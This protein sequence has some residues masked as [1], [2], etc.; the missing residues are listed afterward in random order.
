MKRR[1]SFFFALFFAVTGLFVF[2]SCFQGA[3]DSDARSGERDGVQ[4]LYV[5]DEGLL[6][7]SS[8][9]IRAD[10]RIFS[11]PF[12]A[13][14]KDL[15]LPLNVE[16]FPAEAFEKLPALER[17][18]CVGTVEFQGNVPE[19]IVLT[20]S[21][22]RAEEDPFLPSGH[23]LG[24]CPG[25][26]LEKCL[27]CDLPLKYEYSEHHTF[28]VRYNKTVYDETLTL[29]GKSL[30]V[31]RDGILQAEGFLVL[32]G[33]TRYYESGQFRTGKMDL[34]GY[35]YSFSQEGAL[36]SWKKLDDRVPVSLIVVPLLGLPFGV[37]LCFL[38]RLLYRKKNPED[39]L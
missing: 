36:L 2:S 17:V 7:L 5:E 39:V 15:L 35:R 3:Q 13:E 20:Q 18:W 22:K 12:A 14:V 1:I 8:G 6:I 28:V 21:L 27:L 11:L 33:Q 34:E 9:T 24:H 38:V 37:G 30:R 25:E 31:D 23:I 19:N 32:G 29:E 16:S 10:N 26:M 4:F